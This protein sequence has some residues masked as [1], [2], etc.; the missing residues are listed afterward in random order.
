MPVRSRLRAW[1]ATRKSPQL[2]WDAAQL[3]KVGIVAGGDDTAVAQVGRGFRAMA[4]VSSVRTAAGVSVVGAVPAA[5]A[6]GRPA[7]ARAACRAGRGWR[8]GRTGHAGVRSARRC[9]Q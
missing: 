8:T 3:V 9:G 1:S 6:P 2:V 7:A 4:R 5:A